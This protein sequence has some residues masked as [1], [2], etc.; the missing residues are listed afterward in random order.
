MYNNLNVHNNYNS[1]AWRWQ[2]RTENTTVF[3]LF[4]VSI[5]SGVD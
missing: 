1:I 2:N 5:N 3:L 4:K